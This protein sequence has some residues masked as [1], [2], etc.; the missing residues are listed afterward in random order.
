MS[1][2]NRVAKLEQRFSGAAKTDDL[3]AE[4]IDFVEYIMPE[5]AGWDVEAEGRLLASAGKTIAQV[6]E[7]ASNQTPVLPCMAKRRISNSDLHLPPSQ[8]GR[9]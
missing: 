1:I 9:K 7:E 2:K 5:G 4:W 3:L 8:W 6:V